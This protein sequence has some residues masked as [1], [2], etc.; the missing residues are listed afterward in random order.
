MKPRFESLWRVCRVGSRNLHTSSVLSIVLGCGIVLNAQAPASKTVVPP[1]AHLPRITAEG[2]TQDV[3]DSG[4]RLP[5]HLRP[6]ALAR[7]CSAWWKVDRTRAAAWCT[8]SVEAV[9]SVPQ[10][11]RTD[12]RDLRLRTA[13][14]I[15]S[16]VA[17]LN[18]EWGDR[19]LQTI[20]TAKSG[21]DLAALYGG[22]ARNSISD[23][24]FASN[25]ISESLKNGLSPLALE[26]ILALRDTDATVANQQFGELLR[27]INARPTASSLQRLQSVY[28]QLNSQT[29]PPEWKSRLLSTFANVL[30][31]S[32]QSTSSDQF[33]ELAR[34]ISASLASVRQLVGT[35]T[36]QN[37]QQC[38]RQDASSNANDPEQSHIRDQTL[39]STDDFLRA[40]TTSQ[41]PRLKAQLQLAAAQ[42]AES[43]D[44]D[45][46]RALSI[47][48]D[49]NPADAPSPAG[50]LRLILV[51][52]SSSVTRMLER[53]DIVGATRLF[54]RAPVQVRIPAA[55]DVAQKALGKKLNGVNEM[56]AIADSSINEMA[57][58][59]PSDYVRLLNLHLRVHSPAETFIPQ[60][61]HAVDTW[62]PRVP[63]PQKPL[64][65]PLVSYSEFPQAAALSP[66]QFS[67]EI[68]ELDPEWL[69]DVVR[70]MSDDSV[71]VTIQI[72]LIKQLLDNL[73]KRAPQRPEIKRSSRTN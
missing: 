30:V 2:L 73:P 4:W 46:E 9:T 11:E 21:A 50:Y 24:Q 22:A 66:V 17:P 14:A 45:P 47:L 36:Q 55:I 27:V 41:N 38:S 18:R 43:S 39:T 54:D 35:Q 19:V 59:D 23:P 52:L 58:D 29:V 67:S 40:A 33:C 49:I 61:L 72:T 53:N 3:I 62:K 6:L 13:R 31:R 28:L 8:D 51:Y 65:I 1:D 20:R 56:I 25:M 69:R 26:A 34:A 63:D 57:P 32:Q 37:I 64:D 7:L 70:G 16:V 15:F 42:S 68:L 5:K 60:L 48:L 10:N 44:H 12:E 71:R